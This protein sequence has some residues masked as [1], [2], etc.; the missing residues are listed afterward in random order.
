MS[1][2]GLA[3]SIFL[4]MVVGDLFY[5]R[6]AKI[7]VN[8]TSRNGNPNLPTTVT[9][10]PFKPT[11]TLTKATGAVATSGD[12]INITMSKNGAAMVPPQTIAANTPIFEV[13]TDQGDIAQYKSPTALVFKSDYVYTYDVQVDMRYITVTSSIQQWG[14]STTLSIENQNMYGE[15]E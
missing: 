1:T 9:L 12:A 10:L 13:Q 15:E 6:M 14:A 8:L 7:V 2:A 3:A 4:A 11:A 5:H